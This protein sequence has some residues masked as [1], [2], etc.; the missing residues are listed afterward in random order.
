MV[1]PGDV[2]NGHCNVPKTHGASGPALVILP[3]WHSTVSGYHRMERVDRLGRPYIE[4]LP[5]VLKAIQTV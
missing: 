2:Q 4:A 5:T 1:L 3:C